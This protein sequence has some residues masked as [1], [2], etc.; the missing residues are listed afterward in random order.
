MNIFIQRLTFLTLVMGSLSVIAGILGMNYKVDF[1]E[2]QYG[3]WITIS[4]M[5]LI[6]LGLTIYARFKGWI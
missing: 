1:F 3:F 2:S 6:A 5:V 4:G